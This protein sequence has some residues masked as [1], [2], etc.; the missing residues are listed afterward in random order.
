MVYSTCTLNKEENEEILEWTCNELDIEILDIEAKI[1]KD[2]A[3]S[4]NIVPA[5]SDIANIKKALRILPSKET[6]GF[7]VARLRKK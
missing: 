4:K 5:V 7:F 6:E 2:V 1:A 3:A